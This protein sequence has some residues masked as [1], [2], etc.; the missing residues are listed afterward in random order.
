MPEKDLYSDLQRI[1]DRSKKKKQR[2]LSGRFSSLFG[3]GKEEN[4][5]DEEDEDK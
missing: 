1:E 3:R 2:G 5:E 4:E